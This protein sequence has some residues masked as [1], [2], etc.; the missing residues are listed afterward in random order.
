M[1]VP[2]IPSRWLLVGMLSI[3]DLR[4]EHNYRLDTERHATKNRQ[5]TCACDRLKAVSLSV[6][7]GILIGKMM[8]STVHVRVHG[9][10]LN[11]GKSAT[12]NRQA[13]HVSNCLERT[14]FLLQSTRMQTE[15]T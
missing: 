9:N 2:L 15:R 8:Y 6:Q 12:E 14:I 10:M 1:M 5:S 4:K 11:K 13:T 3:T 7:W